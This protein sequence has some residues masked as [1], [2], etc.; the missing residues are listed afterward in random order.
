M[1][2]IARMPVCERKQ[3]LDFLRKQKRKRKEGAVKHQTKATNV[4]T[5]NSSNKSSSSVNNDW[6]NWVL[7]HGKKEELAAD[8]RDLGK[9]VGVKFQCDSSNSFNLLT[10]ERRKEWRAA[11]GGDVKWGEDGVFLSEDG[12]R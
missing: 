2:K 8:V 7:L 10:R 4:S 3:I 5:S 6:E 1:K 11:R 9:V 12:V